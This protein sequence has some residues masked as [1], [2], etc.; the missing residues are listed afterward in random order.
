VYRRDPVPGHRHRRLN[1]LNNTLVHVHGEIYIDDK[2]LKPGKQPYQFQ[3]DPNDHSLMRYAEVIKPDCLAAP[4]CCC[5]MQAYLLTR[6]YNL[7]FPQ[8]VARL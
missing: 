2:Q 4:C 1:L 7:S 5:N 6:I 8:M 3:G